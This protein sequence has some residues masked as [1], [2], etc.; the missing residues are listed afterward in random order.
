MNGLSASLATEYGKFNITSNILSLGYFKSNLWQA[1]PNKI[2]KER[3]KDIP[4]RKL[5]SIKN[6]SNAIEF[7][8]NSEYVNK[9]IIK[10]DGGI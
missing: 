2:K 3:L 6:I 5:G 8:I 4:S 10:I 1:I 9:S 7:I